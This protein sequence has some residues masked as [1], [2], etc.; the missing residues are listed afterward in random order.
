VEYELSEHQQVIA[1]LYDLQKTEPDAEKRRLLERGIRFIRNDEL[2]G[3]L[4]NKATERNG[5]R[6]A[7]KP[8]DRAFAAFVDKKPGFGPDGECWK[9][10]GSVLNGYAHFNGE[11]AARTAWAR[12]HPPKRLGS[13]QKVIRSCQ[14]KL[15]V[16]PAHLSLS[17]SPFGR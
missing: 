11:L 3:K 14:N 2:V 12:A 15:C 17:L 16:N 13:H 1:I 6:I 4:Q 10:G 8:E 7:S 9:W 5:V